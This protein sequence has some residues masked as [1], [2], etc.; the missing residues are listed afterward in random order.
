[1]HSR[2][3][4]QRTL[5]KYPLTLEG[6]YVSVAVKRRATLAAPAGVDRRRLMAASGSGGGG[7]VAA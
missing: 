4:S 7:V 1:M 3:R 6:W 2:V 5:P